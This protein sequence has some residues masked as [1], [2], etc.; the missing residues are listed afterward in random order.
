MLGLRC[1]DL[2]LVDYARALTWQEEVLRQRCQGEGKDTLLLLEHPPVFTLGRGGDQRHLLNPRQVPVYRVGRGG[3]VTFHGPGQVVGY[4]IL[5]LTRHG[6]DVHAYLRSLEAVLIAVLAEYGL[7]ARR[8]DGLTGVWVGERKIASIGVGVRRW[9]TYHGFAL[10]VDPELSYF[11][12]IVPCG[13]A[14][15]RM[16]SMA[17]LLDRPVALAGVK[18]AIARTFADHFG[19]KELAWQKYFLTPD[20]GLRTPDVVSAASL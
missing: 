14:G 7:R 9:V 6:R 16:T 12:D 2:G 17:Q 11:A 13:L 15:V 1:I 10:N 8:K 20:C 18:T 19:Y 4:P 3:D 5:D